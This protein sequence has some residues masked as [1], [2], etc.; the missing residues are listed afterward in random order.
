MTR[1]L[2]PRFWPREAYQIGRWRVSA[3]L[4][5]IHRV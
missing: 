3:D 2:A 5:L 4:A 1:H